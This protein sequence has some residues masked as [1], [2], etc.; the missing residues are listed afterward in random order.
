MFSSFRYSACVSSLGP[1]ALAGACLLALRPAG[2]GAG[3]RRSAGADDAAGK[4]AAPAV[5]PDRAVAVREPPPQ[6]PAAQVPGGCRFPPERERRRP[7]GQAAP[8]PLRPG[9]AA[10]QPQRRGDAFDPSAAEGRGRCAAPARG[11]RSIGAIIEEDFAGHPGQGPLDLQGVGRGVPQGALPRP[12]RAADPASR[13][14]AR[15]ASAKEAYDLAY[16][17]VLRK[18]YEQAEMGFRQFLQSY[19]ARPARR[20][21]DLL[22]RRELFPAPALSRGGRAVPEDHRANIPVRGKAPDS[23]LKLGMALNGLGARDQACATY[24]KV[25]VDY[26]AASNAVRAGRRARA[27]PLRLRLR[28]RRPASLA[29][30]L[31]SA[32][33]AARGARRCSPISQASPPRSSPSPAAPIRWPCSGFWRTGRSG[34]GRPGAHR[35][36]R[37]ITACAPARP[38][39]LMAVAALCTRSGRRAQRPALGRCQARDRPAGA[40]RAARYDLLAQEAGV[41]A[42][43]RS[44]P[45]IRRRSGRDPA[46]ADG[47]WLGTRR[48]RRHGGAQYA[49]RNRPASAA[50]VRLQGPTRRDRARRWVCPSSPTPAMTRR[51]S[52]GCAGAPWPRASRRRDSTPTGSSRSRDGWRG[53]RPRSTSGPGGFGASWPWHP[54]TAGRGASPSPASST[55]PRRLAL[56]VLATVL[57]DVEGAAAIRLERLETCLAALLTAAREGRTITRTLSGCV[58]TLSRTGLLTIRREGVR[59]RGLH[60][61]PSSR[62]KNPRVSL[63]KAAR[64]T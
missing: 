24:A 64:R 43:V 12:R 40:A 54:A 53:W 60:L 9:R 57:A 52:S 42:A 19:P 21:R 41:S 29:K 7:A 1:R 45:P 47:A 31:R 37:S 25:G 51:A 32:D 34:R 15:P 22:A 49:G 3:R 18:E 50:S 20:R 16:A 36:P 28:T 13:R 55:S 5:G 14:P 63:G 58:L 48:P 61:V 39:R 2:L 46:D 10:R 62:L 17:S 56:R 4:P 27:P 23:L 44:S 30:A 26:P 8:S 35:P 38:T 59:Q 6:R 33:F 11:R